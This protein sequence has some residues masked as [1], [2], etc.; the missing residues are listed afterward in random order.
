ME[1]LNRILADWF[2]GHRADQRRFIRWLKGLS[3]AQRSLFFILLFGVLP[4]TLYF[5]FFGGNY[6]AL[7]ILVHYLI[8]ILLF[9]LAI[10]L[11][12]G[13]Y[14]AV[15]L[16]KEA[17][18]E[19]RFIRFPDGLDRE[20]FSFGSDDMAILDC[21]FNLMPM[22]GKVNMRRPAKNRNKGDLL[23]LFTFLDF[24]LIGG[25]QDFGPRP[26]DSLRTLITDSFTLMGA[27]INPNTFYSSYSRWN[28]MTK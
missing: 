27:E 9:S 28:Q 18:G 24:T 13:W 25:I 1:G 4:L 22:E 11:V 5:L 12:V 15:S 23:F 6:G 10:W 7:E 21:L 26:K 16:E 14:R 8:V 17:S 19:F 3:P 2:L 20:Y